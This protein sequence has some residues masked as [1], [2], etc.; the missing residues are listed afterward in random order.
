MDREVLIGILEALVLKGVPL[1]TFLR[2][3]KI[4]HE[5]FSI[6]DTENGV[7]RTAIKQRLADKY[8]MSYKNLE[9]IVYADKRK[10]NTTK[11]I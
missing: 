5:Y 7:N 8:F 11:I 1:Q 3:V 10:N 9:G 6:I 2:D 4:R